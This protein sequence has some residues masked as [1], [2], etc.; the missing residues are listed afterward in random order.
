VNVDGTRNVLALAMA[1]GVRRI[2]YTGSLAVYGDTRGEVVG[3]AD[4]YRGRLV[5]LYDRSKHRA[6][7]EVIDP[8][9][10]LKAPILVLQP[11][12]IYG[13]GDPTALGKLLTRYVLG[14]VPVVPSGTAYSW[15][16]VQD[17]ADV[18][19]AAMLH[20]TPGRTYVVG[21]PHHTLREVLGIVARVVG[22][23]RGPM[24]LPGAAFRPLAAAAA[25]LGLVIPPLRGIADSIR[26]TA[27]VTYLGDDGPA[28]EQLGFDPRPVADG[29]PDT[30]RALLQELFDEG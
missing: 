1:F 21:G 18:H 23:R 8:L 12:V 20:G 26:A 11:G 4:G 5:T 25:A 28:R 9:L 7:V 6:R 14:R 19:L 17:V 22:K 29:I 15:G 24:P 30:V 3:A 2:V 27:G 13:P 10:T 16:H